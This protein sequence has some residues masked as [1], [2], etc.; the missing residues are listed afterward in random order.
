MEKKKESSVEYLI[1]GLW[2]LENQSGLCLFEEIYN[3]F[4]KEGISSD[5][6]TSFL[7]ALLTFADE[8][9]SDAI[10]HIQLRNHKIIFDLTKYVLFVV[11][12]NA[13]A[14]ASDAEIKYAIRKIAKVFN[15]KFQNVFKKGNWSGNVSIFDS[16]SDDL[17]QI[18]KR[19]PLTLKFLTV[20]QVINKFQDK[21]I[22]TTQYYSKKIQDFQTMQM[23]LTKD[24]L[25]Q[26]REHIFS[27]KKEKREKK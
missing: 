16:F 21:I 27:S 14:P 8:A 7:L 10:L 5:L 15:K 9:F 19:E 17:K 6:I 18:V 3:D 26:A 22:K 12:I 20:Q 11:A 1:D 2:I 4:T 24:F 25:K 23:K 13:K